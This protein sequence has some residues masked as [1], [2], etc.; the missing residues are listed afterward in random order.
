VEEIA[1]V[2]PLR[3]EYLTDA[4]QGVRARSSDN[5]LIRERYG[6]EPAT[7]LRDGLTHTYAWV[8]DR[9]EAKLDARRLPSA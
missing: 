9:V 2:G 6:W 1:G 5:T 4:P 8:F 3:R 7:A